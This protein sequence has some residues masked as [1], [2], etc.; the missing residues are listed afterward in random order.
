MF[1]ANP[2]Q[3]EKPYPAAERGP[4]IRAAAAPPFGYSV[5]QRRT[6]SMNEDTPDLV[7]ELH[8]AVVQRHHAEEQ[9]KRA[10]V[11]RTHHEAVERYQTERKRRDELIDERHRAA[12]AQAGLTSPT[13]ELTV[14]FTELPEAKPDSPLYREWNTYR[15]EVRRFLA[16]GNE[17]RHVLIKSEEIIG[18]WDTHDM[19]MT[20]GYS[21]FLGQP[22]LVHQIQER[23]RVLRCVTTH[24][25]RN[26]HF[27]SRQAS[28]SWPS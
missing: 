8:R 20:E 14:H 11:E 19:A 24:Q 1:N 21:R 16:E 9:Y 22:F 3:F 12:V 28:Q 5:R 25:W 27:P 13:P 4:A 10:L 15:R 26:L 7:E 23:E 2:G 17:G 18:F 6:R